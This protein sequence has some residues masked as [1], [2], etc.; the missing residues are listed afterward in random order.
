M[1]D[2]PVFIIALHRTGSTLLKNILN[3][4]SELAMA[5]DEMQLYLPFLKSYAKQ[6]ATFSNLQNDDKL[7]GLVN[8]LFTQE[9]KG[10]FWKEYRKLGIT[11]EDIFNSLKKTD[12]SLKSVITVLLNQYRKLEQK[13]RVGVKYPLHFS[14][15]SV[16]KD[17]YPD[18]KFILLNRDIRAIC[19]SKLNDE[20][21]QRR[22]IRF[23]FLIHYITLFIFIVDYVNLAR[24]YSK[25]KLLFYK[26]NYED[27]I[28]RPDKELINLCTYCEIPYEEEMLDAIGKP[29]SH[30][31]IVSKGVDEKRVSQ[32]EHKLSKFDRK[33]IELTTYYSRKKLA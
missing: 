12:R 3:L 16:L 26:I 30:T 20:A 24:Y 8:F 14:K 22:K 2:R 19:A 7:R 23:G 11:Q 33:L 9:I 28:M 15:T 18:A 10:A 13:K 31:G 32:W 25:N 29:S 5:T 1:L 27:F 21:T 6:Y 4:N 17:W